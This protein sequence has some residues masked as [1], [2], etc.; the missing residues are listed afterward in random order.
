MIRSLLSALF[1]T[2]CITSFSNAQAQSP[3][4]SSITVT[5]PKAGDV[6]TMNPFVIKATYSGELT[7]PIVYEYMIDNDG[8]WRYIGESSFTGGTPSGSS[9]TWTNPPDISTNVAQ[10]RLRDAAGVIGT[11][12]VF[13][14]EAAPILEG[15]TVND[16]NNPIP[17]DTDIQITWNVSGE[18][19]LIDLSYNV[20]G[21]KTV[22]AN[23]LPGTTTSYTWH[24]PKT[25]MEDVYFLLQSDKAPEIEVGPYKI[26]EVASLKN[27]IVNNG[28]TP[29]PAGKPVEIKWTVVGEPGMID[30]TYK[31]GGF[32]YP[33]TSGLAGTTTSYTWT[34]PLTTQ[35][36]VYVVL[37]PSNA[38]KVEV[39]PFALVEE[40]GVR[41]KSE[42]AFSISVYPNPTSDMLHVAC[43]AAGEFS[44]ILTDVT[45]KQM[46]H[47]AGRDALDLNVEALPAGSYVVS[48]QRGQDVVSQTVSIQR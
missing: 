16:G 29:L 34:T 48:V 22:I 14:F 8:F 23:N 13:K 19:G 5:S 9:F 7:S 17:L 15:L 26:A 46:V 31:I 18:P 43:G 27:V 39:G 1:L 41:S 47:S 6:L 32:S 25:P 4:G 28:V 37:D 33:I 12:G 20:D 10:I 2:L 42:A 24:S 36:E 21:K 3:Q 44:V 11:S 40:S 30:L 35:P 38:Q 45:G